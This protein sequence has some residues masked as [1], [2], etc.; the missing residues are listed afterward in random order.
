[1]CPPPGTFLPDPMAGGELPDGMHM[2]GPE[3]FLPDPMAEATMPD[4]MHMEML[5]GIFDEVSNETNKEAPNNNESN[6]KLPLSVIH[7]YNNPETEERLC[8]FC[9][10]RDNFVWKSQPDS[11]RQQLV[12]AFCNSCLCR[13]NKAPSLLCN[14]KRCR[15][16]R[17]LDNLGKPRGP[18]C[19]KCWPD[20]RKQK[21]RAGGGLR[22]KRRRR[23]T[24]R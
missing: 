7:I 23:K 20:Y 9:R 12:A 2:G 5:N 3:M 8:G 6:D 11:N 24:K 22:R 15:N 16:P 17:C 14:H 4:D 10:N 18:V 19:S 21:N 13:L 1:M